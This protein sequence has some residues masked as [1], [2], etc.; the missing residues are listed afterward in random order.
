M[1][2]RRLTCFGLLFNNKT[3]PHTAGKPQ[4]FCLC[5]KSIL[6]QIINIDGYIIIYMTYVNKTRRCLYNYLLEGYCFIE[7]YIYYCR[8]ITIQNA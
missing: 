5:K 6:K 7:K 4:T 2:L 8:Q 1:M 3:H